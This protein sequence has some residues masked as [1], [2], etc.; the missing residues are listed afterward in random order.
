MF[1]TKNLFSNITCPYEEFCLLPRCIFKHSN[2]PSK[3]S[4]KTSTA[5]IEEEKKPET[6]ESCLPAIPQVLPPNS[7]LISDLDS[8]S[9]KKKIVTPDNSNSTNTKS[10][11]KVN[12][13]V[14]KR[15]VEAS[16]IVDD[17]SLPALKRKTVD[18]NSVSVNMRL[19]PV[20]KSLTSSQLSGLKNTLSEQT[21]N[22]VSREGLNPRALKV[23]APASHNMR[24][25]LLKA[26]YS[27]FKRLNTELAIDKKSVQAKLVLSDQ[28]LITR[29]L[30][31]E[32]ETAVISPLIYANLIK[33]KI[34]IY[35]RMNVKQWAEERENEIIQAQKALEARSSLSKSGTAPGKTSEVIKLIET[36]LSP[37]EELKFLPELKIDFTKT[38]EHGFVTSIPTDQEI[39]L[40]Q[41]GIEAANGWEI[42]DRCKSR[43]QVFP[44]RR[45]EDG[46][47][48]SGG[49]CT[50]HHGRTYLTEISTGSSKRIKKYR[51]CG[52]SLSDSHGCTTAPCHV[53]KISEVKRLASILN[54]QNTPTPDSNEAITKQKRQPI[55]L[56]GEMGYTVNGL[57]L[58]RLTAISWPSG[59]DLFDVLVRPM[60]PIL[61]LNSRFSG[62]YPEHMAN[63]LPWTP[64][65]SLPKNSKSPHALPILSSVVEARSLL[66]SYLS[67]STPLI[68]HGLENDL[69]AMRIIH[70]TIIDTAFLFPHKLGLPY[71]N[72][73]KLL[74]R[75]YLNRNIQDAGNNNSGEE[76]SNSLAGH[77]S[78]EDAFAAGELVKYVLKTRKEKLG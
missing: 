5:P 3:T 35:K 20:S 41:K 36:G 12:D 31:F 16:S 78:K 57:E 75:K 2:I 76:S 30:D 29:A 70:P 66:F 64:N 44:G 74:A 14:K 63:A 21:A 77:D 61:D 51:C 39:E 1:S 45:E 37:E 8:L 50:Y 24:Y 33:N 47:L 43:F 48:T 6:T 40:A 60:G 71:R 59:Q 73:L 62:V 4:L 9:P 68:G 23:P 65:Q 17:I 52:E 53:F 38:S 49:Q 26:L 72:S 42:C 54:F 13:Q 46:A 56:D 11:S 69:N 28:S 67:S 25:Q 32:E 22:V 27:Q 34:L 58:I 19:S 7:S 10:L 55:C 15:K 18:G